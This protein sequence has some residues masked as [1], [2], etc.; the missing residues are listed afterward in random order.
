MLYC[1]A[2]SPT[3]FCTKSEIDRITVCQ[4]YFLPVS[5]LHE[6]KSLFWHNWLKKLQNDK[7]IAQSRKMIPK[8]K[9]YFLEREN[10]YPQLIP[11]K[12]QYPVI[13]TLKES[14]RLKALLF[15]LSQTQKEVETL[16]NFS[17]FVKPQ[18]LR[19]VRRLQF[20]QPCRKNFR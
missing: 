12:A 5:F 19:K 4:C 15:F 9:K 8:R 6:S 17:K 20:W 10:F 16:C 13:K 7:E 14:F 2:E 1:F 3:F 18:S 11:L